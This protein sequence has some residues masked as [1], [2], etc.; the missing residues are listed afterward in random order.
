MSRLT[1]R[2]FL[3]KTSFVAAGGLIAACAAPAAPAA[4]GDGEMAPSMEML[5]LRVGAIAGI[6]TE[7]LQAL[8]D[9]YMEE[10][11]NISVTIDVLADEQYQQA[12]LLFSS[13]GHAGRLVVSVRAGQSFQRHG[14][15]PDPCPV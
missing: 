6:V 11:S 7:G 2:D 13:E 10:N 4:E 15:K 5:E 9:L 8:A 1:R 12:F 14:D 3:Q